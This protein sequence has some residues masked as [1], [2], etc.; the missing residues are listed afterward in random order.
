MRAAAPMFVIS[1][2]FLATVAAL[3]VVW[4]DLPRVEPGDQ[5]AD[6]EVS[7]DDT[8][9]ADLAGRATA[10]T[11]GYLCLGVL[12]LLWPIF[13]AEV[14]VYWYL[15]GSNGFAVRAHLF[16]CL[17]PPL[18]LGLA[19]PELGGRIWLPKFGWSRISDGL[20]QRLEKVFGIPMII[21]ALMI[22]PILLLEFGFRDQVAERLWLR[23]ILH[24]STG[25]IWFA[26]ALEFIIMCS[27]A[28]RKLQYC[29]EHWLDLAIILLPLISFLRSMRV[30]RATRLGRLAKLQQLTKM[31]RMYRLRGLSIKAFRALLLFEVINRLIGMTPERQVR[32]LRDQLARKE[33]EVGSLRKKIDEIERSMI[34]QNAEE[35]SEA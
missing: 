31:V 7:L 24:I 21:I 20:R 18:R 5:T 4:V 25:M 23:N 27:V 30:V 28:D 14:L 35:R 26:F 2:V 13:F 34:S 3:I 33:L 16:A 17:C 15:G 32:N 29:K 8:A 1:L 11:L 10:L 19:H 9:T 12:G 6:G 22:L